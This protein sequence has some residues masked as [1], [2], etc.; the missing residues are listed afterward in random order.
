[1]QK[2]RGELKENEAHPI[3]SNATR[4]IFTKINDPLLLESLASCAIESNRLAEVCLE[5]IKR[6]K[7]KEP[8]GERYLLGLAWFL[9]FL[10]D[11][12]KE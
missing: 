7:S 11:E 2:V 9:K 12:E 10:E 4:Y 6:I 5:T 1:M 3:V 8:I